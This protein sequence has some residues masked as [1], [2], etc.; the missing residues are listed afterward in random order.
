[1]NTTNAITALKIA[2]ILAAFILTSA[3]IRAEEV[4]YLQSGEEYRGLLESIDPQSGRTTFRIGDEVKTWD[5]AAIDRIDFER[6]R[7]FN[8]CS[9]AEELAKA[10][11]VFARA[12]ELKT[13]DLEKKYPDAG[14]VTL[15]SKKR[16]ILR[17]DGTWVN[18][19]WTVWRIL[20]EKGEDTAFG[21]VAFFPEWEQAEIV[22]G[23]T[24][25]PDGKVSHL[26]DAALKEE[27]LYGDRPTYDHMRRLRYTLKGPNPGATFSVRTRVSGKADALHPFLEEAIFG[28]SE[29]ALNV[30]VELILEGGAKASVEESN[31]LKPA[32]ASPSG[33]EL[34]WSADETPQIL[35]EPMMPPLSRFLPR[36]VVAFPATTW[37]DAASAYGI[38]LDAQSAPGQT[39]KALA[40]RCRA[41]LKENATGMDKAKAA[42]EVLRTGVKLDAIHPGNLP[43]VQS[44]PEQTAERGYGTL[45]EKT[46][47]LRAVLAELG[48]DSTLALAAPRSRAASPKAPSLLG[49]ADLILRVA[50]GDGVWLMSGD[51]SSG[52]GELDADYQ[53]SRALLIPSGDW[54]EIPPRELE[55]EGL[56]ATFDV[57]IAENGTAEIS[58]TMKAAGNNARAYRGLKEMT[59]A[60][61]ADWALSEVA[62]RLPGAHLVKIEHSDFA[63][64][65]PQFVLTRQYSVPDCAQITG[66]FILMRLPTPEFNPSQVGRIERRYDMFWSGGS[67]VR[68]TVRITAP[69]GY[70][71]Y[72][73]PEPVRA[74]RS[75]WSYAADFKV[76]SEEPPVVEFKEDY[77][78]TALD[79]PKGAYA[80]LRMTLISRAL[81]QR[82][83]IVLKK[84]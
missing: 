60:E 64:A 37:K 34:S 6:P 19:S 14:I 17:G 32:S 29:P 39:V 80:D 72:S 47:L 71:V 62:A 51:E 20:K 57:K 70:S 56:E 63:T 52:F 73:L 48:V 84:E 2:A 83:W 13:E 33:T 61:L 78:R 24:V 7:E 40:Q 66:E 11:P 46:L 10:E 44:S 31:G 67:L 76:V 3:A 79:A 27:S 65:E 16:I 9:T 35:P 81:T 55:E 22:H 36:L 5:L 30:T 69:A 50:V 26:S 82:Q 25:S 1:M 41:L 15:C 21:T 54:V 23:L 4:L 8:D 12:L 49:S 58:E 45:T 77:R 38:A 18:D 75:G 28:G 68:N 43:L 53:A 74:G 42:F 59:K